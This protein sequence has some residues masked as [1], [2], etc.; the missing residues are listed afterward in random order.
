VQPGGDVVVKP[1]DEIIGFMTNPAPA[2]GDV[3]YA[4]THPFEKRQGA[5]ERILVAVLA[6]RY[7]ILIFFGFSLFIDFGMHTGG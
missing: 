2:Q 4:G 6:R 3:G 7:I 5:V 1:V